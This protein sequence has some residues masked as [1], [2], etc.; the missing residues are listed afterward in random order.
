MVQT[1]VQSSLWFLLAS[2]AGAGAMHMLQHFME[3]REM[4]IKM[5]MIFLVN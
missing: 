3:A 2:P 4:G 5:P 1:L